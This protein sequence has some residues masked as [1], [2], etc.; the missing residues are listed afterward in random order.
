MNVKGKI[1]FIIALKSPLERK[2][3]SSRKYLAGSHKVN[4]AMFAMGWK[5]MNQRSNHD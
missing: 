5:D 3:I 2:N 4:D 1:N